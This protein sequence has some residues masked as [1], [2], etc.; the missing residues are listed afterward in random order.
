[1]IEN[2]YCTCKNFINLELYRKNQFFVYN[3]KNINITKKIIFKYLFKL[4]LY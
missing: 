4:E 3:S 2:R 1:M